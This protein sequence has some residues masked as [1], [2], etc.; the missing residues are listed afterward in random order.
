MSKHVR[1]QIFFT[2]LPG[3]EEEFV[4]IK[5]KMI[6]ESLTLKGLLSSTSSKVLD[7][8][9][10]W[11][12]TMIWEDKAAALD[13]RNTF[14]ALTTAGQFMALMA[15]PPVAEFMMEFVPDRSLAPA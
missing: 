10:T 7:Q 5:E 1:H 4:S 14:G 15:G 6:E 11:V 12:D 13:S 3:K 2:I 8:E 9:N